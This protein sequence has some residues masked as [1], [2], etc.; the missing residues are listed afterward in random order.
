MLE[1]Q[2]PPDGWT[3]V[4]RAIMKQTIIDVYSSIPDLTNRFIIVA[5]FEGGYT[6]TDIAAMLGISQVA[7]YKRLTKTLNVVRA[8]KKELT[9]S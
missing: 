9:A 2:P 5:H 8:H 7:V 3:A 6:Q 4:E 1:L